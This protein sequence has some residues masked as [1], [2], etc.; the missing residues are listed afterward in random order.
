MTTANLRV[1]LVEDSPDDAALIV[2]EL[3]HG[4]FK[5]YF[6]RVETPE[7]FGG[8]LKESWDAIV[9][10]WSLPRFSGT[11]ALAMVREK[12]LDIPF[13]L[14]SGTIGEES[15]VEAMRSG[16]HDYLM[17]DKLARLAPAIRREL[18][19]AA[20]RLERRRADEKLR[21]SLKEKETLLQE[22]HHRVKNNLQ[23]ICS[24]INLQ[25]KRI[26]NQEVQGDLREC[27]DRV[28]TMALLHERLYRS[29][30]LDRID[31]SDYARH[32]T[33][34]LFASHGV[35]PKK[36]RLDLQAPAPVY[37]GLDEA[38]PCGLILHEVLSNGLKHAFP[39]ER[40]GDI[41]IHVDRPAPD[42]VRLRVQ[43]TGV[44]FPSGINTVRPESL[45]LQ[46][47]RNLADQI[48]AELIL[49][50]EGGVEFEIVFHSPPQPEPASL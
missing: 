28:K 15:A 3:E 36:V 37:L 30:S 12:K 19:E 23:I 21:A 49:R 1:L 50:Q 16:A 26:S 11:A 39:N 46:L 5:L 17:K 35:D 34:D 31:F 41:R 38:L 10:D 27:R 13:I 22:I 48:H 47:V 14:V 42:K 18:K 9:A 24:L 43:D 32:L 44:G 25:C 4:G 33:R 29:P 40:S 7:A 6:Q 45:G 8:A 20:M 2:R